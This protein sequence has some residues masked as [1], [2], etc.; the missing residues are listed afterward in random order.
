MRDALSRAMRSTAVGVVVALVLAAYLAMNAMSAFPYQL[1]IDFYQFWGVPVAKHAAAIPHSPYVDP[2]SYARVLNGISD[3]SNSDKLH[4]ANAFRRNLEPM[5]TPF[6]YATFS[7]FPEDYDRAQWLF[8]LA[9]YIA[10]GLG[11]FRLARLRGAPVW[12]A[13]WIAIV[14]ELTFTPF[15]IDVKVGN[16]NSLQLAFIAAL[17]YL[18]L[19]RAQS[20]NALVDG[21]FLGLLALF[22]MFKPNTPWIA[23][24]LGIHYWV[25]GGHRRFAIGLG[26][27]A[28]FA[29]LAFAIGAVYFKDAL[30]WGEWLQLARG[31]DGSGLPLTLAN[32]N[33]SLTM[34]L[35][36]KTRSYGAVGYGLIIAV[37]LCVALVVAM[38][39]GGR[40]VDL[41]GPGMR[42]AFSSP[43]FAASIG[44]LFTFATS[45][46]LWP[47]YLVLALV[48][49]FWLFDG[50]PDMGTWC[51]A[52]CYFGMSRPVIDFLISGGHRALLEADT[53]F[54]W[55][56][57][58]PGVFAYVLRQRRALEAPA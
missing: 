28:A 47:H 6:L 37:S 15:M 30:V 26:V 18:A 1:G 42:Q 34:L 52:I 5:G 48:P 24:A 7:V 17:L 4:H 8:T 38:S 43:W 23:L 9:I 39:A 45:P 20:G 51:A 44:I 32:G 12:L 13:V 10:A 19:R 54:A 56:V 3:A 2:P 40:R 46:L 31:M 11:V 21:L 58:V 33:Q 29:L 57:L 16:V 27:A 35:A 41:L 22:V 49:I 36:D 55:V 50:K 25:V 53:I 14:V